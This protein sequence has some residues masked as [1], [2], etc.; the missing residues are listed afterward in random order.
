MATRPNDRPKADIQLVIVSGTRARLLTR[1]PAGAFRTVR[2]LMS[3]AATQRSSALA[4]DRLGRSHESVGSARHAIAPR[5]DPHQKAMAAFITEVAASVSAVAAG[6][7]VHDLVIAGPP[8]VLEALDRA[9]TPDLRTHVRARVGRDL[10]K[11]PDARL[12]EHFP[13]WPLV[14]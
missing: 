11:V 13:A 6:G 14:Q 8:P 7:Q 5:S 12:S 4:R 3:E 10:A 9:L 2:K 1:T